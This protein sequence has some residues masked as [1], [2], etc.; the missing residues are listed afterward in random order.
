MMRQM[1]GQ[2]WALV[3]R[4]GQPGEQGMREWLQTVVAILG[5]AITVYGLWRAWTYAKWEIA[6]R[7]HLLP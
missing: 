6:R 3:A 7:R 5:M 1:D 2:V 4:V